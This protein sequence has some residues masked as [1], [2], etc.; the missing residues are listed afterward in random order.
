[1]LYNNIVPAVFMARPNRF[2]A[3]ILVNGREYVAHVP[4]TGR[5]RELLVPGTS[6]FVQAAHN[7]LRKTPYTVITV[8]K[9]GRLINMDS[10]APNTVWAE[11]LQSKIRLPDIGYI[12]S[13]RREVVFG[14]SRLDFVI[15]A[16]NKK[17]YIEVKGVTLEEN[18]IARFPDAPT[19]RGCKHLKELS[20]ASQQ[21]LFAAAV[22]VI[23]MSDIKHFEPNTV[24]DPAF[25][26]ALIQ[27]KQAGVQLLAYDC[28]IKPDEITLGQSVPIVLP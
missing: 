22:F 25:A 11:A 14:D 24:T 18:G 3:H 28:V 17:G 21:G 23:Q 13:F 4:N 6:I 12:D 10:Q 26:Q 5:C 15:S 20:H 19:E 1:M 2:I 7:P 8:N 9:N 27:A 16:G